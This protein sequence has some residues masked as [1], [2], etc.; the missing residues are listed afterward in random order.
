MR[1][2]AYTSSFYGSREIVSTKRAVSIHTS[3]GGSYLGQLTLWRDSSGGLWAR[4]PGTRGS[5]LGSYRPVAFRSTEKGG[6]YY[7]V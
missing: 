5:I 4:R 7:F 1:G 2:V 6:F 3:F